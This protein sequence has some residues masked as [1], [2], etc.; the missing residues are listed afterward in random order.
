MSPQPDAIS[1]DVSTEDQ[2]KLIQEAREN[3]SGERLDT[4]QQLAENRRAAR[5]SDLE[6][7]GH[8]VVDTS[9]K[10]EEEIPAKEELKEEPE[11]D[12]EETRILKV[13]GEDV[14]YPISK[15][16]DSGVRTLQK[17]ATADARLEEATRLLKEAQAHQPSTDVGHEEDSTPSSID[18]ENLA[19]VLIDGD[20][21]E[22]TNAV[23]ELVGTGRSQPATQDRSEVFSYVQDALN[24]NKAMAL[25]REAPEKGGFGDLY[26]N[27][28]LR[29][30]VMDEEKK[31]SDDGDTRDYSDRLA[32]AAKTVRSFRDD[33]IKDS[34]G[35][36]TGFDDKKDKKLKADNTI[37]GA[38]GRETPRGDAKPKT[39]AQVR[40][41]A[42]EKMA[43]SRGQQID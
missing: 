20:H 42:I 22:V 17:E 12:P 24:V 30:M 2:T 32:D 29:S 5:D 1:E 4:M 39:R 9:G 37:E 40:Q 34:G 43:G 27:E 36:V 18:A 33:M 6:E 7:A 41:S 28:T 14:E 10:E 31:L 23:R 3:A 16:L 11:N 8:N 13:D 19:K 35:I 25:F 21:E 26:K 15:I 38:G